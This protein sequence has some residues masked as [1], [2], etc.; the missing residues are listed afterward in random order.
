MNSR[1]TARAGV[2][3]WLTVFALLATR[4]GAQTA[5]SAQPPESGVAKAPQVLQSE[6]AASAQSD[7]PARG[8][9]G[10]ID[11][12]DAP[13]K[14]FWA[15]RVT[16]Y[17]TTRDGVALRYS[18]LLPA[19]AG[20][21]PVAVIYS[22]YDTG[23]IGGAAYLKNNVTFSADLDRTLVE[24][25]Y[26]VMGVSA[27]AT[28]C[29]GGN[30][31]TFIG[32]TYGEDGGDAIEFAAQQPWSDGNVGM[33]GWSWAG[34][35]QLA[36]ASDRPPH[37]KAI[38]P[39]MTATDLRLDNAAP[40]GV[41]QPSMAWGW[42][43]FLHQRW[44]AV[45]ESAEAEHDDLCLQ[46]LKRNFEL[47]EEN[48]IARNV[49]RHPLRDAWN[50]PE[51]QLNARTQL[52][53][54]PVLSMESFQDEAVSSRDG[55]YQETLDPER[56]WIL[57]TNG[58]HDLY[59]SS[60]F[61]KM[62]V[63]FLDRFVKGER[64]EFETRPHLNVW[65]DT[66]SNGT[67]RNGRVKAATPRWEFA[68]SQLFPVVKPVSFALTEGGQLMAGEY[69]SGKPDA[70]AYPVPGPAVDIDADHP[71]WGPLAADWRKASL[72]YTS[73]PLERDILA[74]GSAS[75]DL[76]LSSDDVPDTDLQVTLTE[77]RSDG[78]EMFLQRGWL[79]LS[80]R[81]LD[82][83]RSTVV[84]PVLWDTP[85]TI[86][87]LDPGRPVLARV[88]INKFAVVLR[89]GSRVRVW[90]DAPSPTGLY[91]FDYVSLPATN[92]IWHDRE[93]P[94]RLVIGEL[95]LPNVQIPGK[96]ARCGTVMMEPCRRDPFAS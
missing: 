48:S 41:A 39:G 25:G 77:V 38:V 28:G 75:M 96:S 4:A 20:R 3:V 73:S 23:S 61:R 70:Y 66:L 10:E 95:E 91:S 83:A 59:E 79:R 36:T 1:V 44:G 43:I 76:W 31:F 81:A 57:Q 33:Y 40:G 42:R 92:E 85:D 21:F 55:Y 71:A 58:Q 13:I 74:Y 50:K 5:N 52:I 35:S 84:R 78:Q 32:P 17:L 12:S 93:H 29:S 72:T 15:R 67:G 45:K 62:L 27:R 86:Q 9:S 94:S 30:H 11:P 24:H 90:I 8:A 80:D 14:K 37:L 26:A 2:R 7:L 63:A 53:S 22:G 6:M 49:L 87:V 68:S 46:H 82:E 18:V 64:N 88:E 69:G 60:Q 54:V 34:M 89:K 51:Q 56:T 47:E 65:M 19:A 16:G